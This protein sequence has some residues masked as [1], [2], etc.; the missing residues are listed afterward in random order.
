MIFSSDPLKRSSFQKGSCGHMIFLVLSGKMLFFPEN[1]IFFHWVQSERRPFPG[2]T[3]KH[4]ASSSEEKQET[5]YIGLKPGFSLNL[6]DWRYSA[7][8]NLQYFVQF[9]P[10]ELCLGVCLGA[11]KGNYL[12]IRG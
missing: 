4:D 5:C 11:N 12:S 3:W 1:M 8:N 6:F 9:S 2:N 7:M 10:Q